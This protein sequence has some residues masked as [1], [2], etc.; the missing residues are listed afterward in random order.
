MIKVRSPGKDTFGSITCAK[1]GKSE[2]HPTLESDKWSAC[3]CADPDR[4]PVCGECEKC[5][6]P[7]GGG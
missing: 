3:Y 2:K 7:F 4:C 1:C 6:D 5:F